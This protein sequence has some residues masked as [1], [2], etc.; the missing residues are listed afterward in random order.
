MAGER[1]SFFRTEKSMIFRFGHRRAGVRRQSFWAIL[2]SK[3]GHFGTQKWPK[4][5]V[6]TQIY[7]CARAALRQ[8]CDAQIWLQIGTCAAIL[9]ARVSKI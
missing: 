1:R 6:A 9:H 3:I 4:I 2:G 7:A 8:I 5:G